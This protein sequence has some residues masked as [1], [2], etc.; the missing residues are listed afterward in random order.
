MLFLREGWELDKHMGAK[1]VP[2][3]G[4][5]SSQVQILT[6]TGDSD[7]LGEIRESKHSCWE[8]T[9]GPRWLLFLLLFV[10]SMRKTQNK[11]KI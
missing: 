5:A 10:S 8:E 2:A 6:L 7:S 9:F 1:D 3:G 11:G 4:R